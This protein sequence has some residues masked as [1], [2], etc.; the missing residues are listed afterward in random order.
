MIKFTREKSARKIREDK[1]VNSFHKTGFVNED[2]FKTEDRD[3]WNA[4]C[5]T[6]SS[7]NSIGIYRGV[8]AG[9]RVLPYTEE[10]A[11]SL[12][13]KDS[14]PD[15]IPAKDRVTYVTTEPQLVK[16]VECL[17]FYPPTFGFDVRR[18]H[19]VNKRGLEI[20]NT[21]RKLKTEYKDFTIFPHII[22]F[23]ENQ[24]KIH[25]IDKDAENKDADLFIKGENP[26]LLVPLLQDNGYYKIHDMVRFP[27]LG[28][29]YYTKRT[30]YGQLEFNYLKRGK[31]NKLTG[32]KGYFDKAI[33][34]N[35]KEEE[36]EIFYVK[37]FANFYHPFLF[38]D[39]IEVDKLMDRMRK[40]SILKPGVL[41]ILES[42]YSLYLQFLEELGGNIPNTIPRIEIW[43]ENDDY[44]DKLD[45]DDDVLITDDEN[46]EED[47]EIATNSKVEAV[48]RNV[49][50]M[51]TLESLIL[52]YNEYI[53]LGFYPHM[54][55]HLM[56][57]HTTKPTQ[58]NKNGVNF[59]SSS[60]A[61]RELMIPKTIKSHPEL[62][63]TFD[64]T[65]F[66]DIFHYMSYKMSLLEAPEDKEK[67]SN[68]S[69]IDVN[70]DK[71]YRTLNDFGLI[72]PYTLKS[73][74]K[75][76]LQGNTSILQFYANH[77]H[78]IDI[79]ID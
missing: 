4:L 6:L 58:V 32:W 29:I 10:L 21:L 67:K 63:R 35:N 24:Q 18:G 8:L 12:S 49:F 16:Y 75:A 61:P 25:L 70:S 1:F 7:T 45:V 34:Y 37:I 77:Y 72:D 50:P 43:K 3:M 51:S 38:F 64:N 13:L 31:Q 40:L 55:Y 71:R 19:E 9:Y 66:I 69:G 52:G 73:A 26:I 74:E 65:N 56:N 15:K 39:K 59:I 22:T 62:F 44:Y 30:Q 20:K 14:K 17:F 27:Y 76:G 47:K 79:S 78:F 23:L 54:G 33:T 41:R 36:I 2:L 28:E 11:Q 42:T 46:E 60:D 5:R 57:I 68:N 48:N 53:I